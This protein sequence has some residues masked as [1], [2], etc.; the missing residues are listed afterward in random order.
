M[1]FVAAAKTISNLHTKATNP[2]T[3]TPSPPHPHP[4]STRASNGGYPQVFKNK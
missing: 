3:P 2:L 4:P 1:V